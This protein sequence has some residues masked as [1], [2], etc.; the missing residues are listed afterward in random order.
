MNYADK[1]LGESVMKED[2]AARIAKEMG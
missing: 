2:Q 1:T